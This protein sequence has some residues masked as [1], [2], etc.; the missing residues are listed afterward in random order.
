MNGAKVQAAVAEIQA[1]YDRTV[2]PN[3]KID[4]T[5]Y[6]TISAISTRRDASAV[7]MEN[8]WMTNSRL[9]AW[10]ATCVILSRWSAARMISSR[11]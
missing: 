7:M 1:I 2:L 11:A 6:Q 8:T 9:S 4:W 10:N 5:T 3:E